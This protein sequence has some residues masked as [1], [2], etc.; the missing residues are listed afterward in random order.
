MK[1]L[2]CTQVVDRDDPVLGFCHRWIEEFARHTERVTVVCLR[3][4][5]HAL[6]DNVTVLSLG[7]EEGVGR[8]GYVLR[9][10]RYAWQ[11]RREYDAVFVHMNTEYVVLGG[12]L[13]RLLRKRIVLWYAH[14]HVP[15]LLRVATALAHTVTTSTESGFRLLTEKKL[16]VGQGIDTER[17]A[18]CAEPYTDG[19]LRLIAVG[20]LSPI[21]HYETLIRAV[22]A[23]VGR[24][25]DVSVGII[26]GV[27][28][29]GQEAYLAQLETLVVD[30]RLRGR[31]VFLGAISNREIAVHLCR[32]H[33][34][35]NPSQTGSLDKAGLEAMASGLPVLTCN[36]AFA[37]VLG[38][39][40]DRL[41]FPRGDHG[42]LAERISGFMGADDRA[43]VAAE[44]RERVVREHGVAQLIPRILETL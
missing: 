42:A 5:A 33:L 6:P 22:A 10:F 4:G 38:E 15:F 23:L 34:F 30:L 28:A 9:F 24:G 37:E 13:W 44:L 20:R 2:I 8:L 1:L 26:G 19:P 14:G 3:E 18:S 16:V 27:G 12:L 39:H 25:V 32:A 41:M 35:V 21:K 31:V 7:K 40:A 11:Q 29:P 43:A 36:E 17:F